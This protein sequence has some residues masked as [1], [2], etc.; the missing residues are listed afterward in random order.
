MDITR[1]AY[2]R[3]LLHETVVRE[4]LLK[5][6]RV[7]LDRLLPLRVIRQ[8]FYPGLTRRRTPASYINGRT[9]RTGHPRYCFTHKIVMKFTAFRYPLPVSHIQILGCSRPETVTTHRTYKKGE[10]VGRPNRSDKYPD[11]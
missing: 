4:L 10:V 8:T 11:R 6:I 7:N 3:L 1:G 5:F 9:T 2:R